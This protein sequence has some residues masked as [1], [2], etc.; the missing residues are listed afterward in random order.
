MAISIRAQTLPPT[1]GLNNPIKPLPFIVNMKKEAG[2]NY[3]LIN[4]FSSGGTFA[5]LILK[6]MDE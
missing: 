3:G 2:I 4:G 1:L 5:S 6:R